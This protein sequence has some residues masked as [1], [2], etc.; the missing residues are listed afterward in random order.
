MPPFAAEALGEGQGGV[1]PQR[2]HGHQSSV[3]VRLQWKFFN[4]DSQYKYFYFDTAR[5]S[6]TVV[7]KVKKSL[8]L[9]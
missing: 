2:L 5:H 9:S 8:N 6:N 1:V 7:L 3:P 4:M